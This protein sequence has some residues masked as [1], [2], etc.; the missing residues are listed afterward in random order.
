MNHAVSRREWMSGLA[1]LFRNGSAQSPSATSA[2]AVDRVA[3]IQGRFCLAYHTFCSTC[4]ERCPEPGA[5]Q[6]ENGIP[7]VVPEHCTGCNI[8]HEVCPA[9][10]NA[11]LMLPRNRIPHLVKS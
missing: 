6:V 8:C 2:A 9:P 11:I 4:S 5:I 7:R 1:R 10:K 3:I